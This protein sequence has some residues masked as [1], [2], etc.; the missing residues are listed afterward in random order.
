MYYHYYTVEL[1]TNLPV[2]R[3]QLGSIE[4]YGQLLLI[5]SLMVKE[6][7]LYCMTLISNNSK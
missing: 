3:Y 7:S 5:L 6:K 2:I 1:Y 4:S